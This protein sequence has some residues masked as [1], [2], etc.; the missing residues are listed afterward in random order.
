MTAARANMNVVPVAIR[1]TR[2]I[3]RADT[4]MPRRGRIT[5]TIGQALS[6]VPASEEGTEG[7]WSAAVK[8]KEAAHQH[9]SRY[10]G[11]VDLSHEP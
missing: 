11:E 3:L 1:G 9:I 10:C 2:S 6:P 4:W 8:L 7:Y 5:I